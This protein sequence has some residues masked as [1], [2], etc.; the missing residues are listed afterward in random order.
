MLCENYR[1]DDKRL[2]GLSPV[3]CGTEQCAP[4][5]SVGFT[6][7]YWMLHFV[8]SGKGTFSTGGVTYDV[9][10][11]QIFVVRPHRPHVYT[12][13]KTDPWHYIWL[14]FYCDT[15][16]L[17]LLDAD[18][19]TAPSLGSLFADC[20]DA[21][22]EE[23]GAREAITA[24]L[25]ALFAA[26]IR[27]QAAHGTR[28]NPYVT[29]A[30]RYIEENYAKPIRVS[31]IARTLNLDRCYF[32][33]VFRRET[34]TSPKQYLAEVRMEHAAELLSAE[35]ESVT[36]AARRAG[37]G[38]CMNFSRHFKAHFGVSPSRY[39]E[40]IAKNEIDG[41]FPDKISERNER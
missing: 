26:L 10:P 14:N 34:G 12:A 29:A 6:R 9:M 37:Y 27:M 7:P 3:W 40:M 16:L 24:G 41:G 18:V 36:S 23:Y 32:S 11:S 30:K 17:A 21:A 20:L 19:I 22:R 35:G 13:D 38:D 2:P 28:Q 31:D 25:W 5:F 15:E 1:F 4:G 39:R 33:T 8:V